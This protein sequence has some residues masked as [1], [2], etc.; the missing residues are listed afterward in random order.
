[1]SKQKSLNVSSNIFSITSDNFYLL[2]NF[3]K[4][5]I[6]DY[7]HLTS[8]FLKNIDQWTI[9]GFENNGK[10][11]GIIYYK[12]SDILSEIFGLEVVDNTHFDVI[13]DLICGAISE[14]INSKSGFLYFFCD[15]HEHNIN[16]ELGFINLTKASCFSKIL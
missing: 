10:V 5:Y 13:K 2:E 7:F 9:L 16:Q 6:S 15:L 11:V 14:C 3:R 8:D 12:K 1:M 4:E